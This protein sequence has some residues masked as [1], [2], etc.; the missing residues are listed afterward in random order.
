MMMQTFAPA[1]ILKKNKFLLKKLKP[2]KQWSPAPDTGT[3]VNLKQKEKT[4][5]ST[6]IPKKTISSEN[7][8]NRLS[9]TACKKTLSKLN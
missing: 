2:A 3:Q 9:S 1:P 5:Y 7:T 8:P 6:N 4:T